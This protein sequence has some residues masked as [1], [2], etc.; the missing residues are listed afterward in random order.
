V[1]TPASVAAEIEQLARQGATP[2][3]LLGMLPAPDPQ[4]VI[5]IL[6]I[7]TVVHAGWSSYEDKLRAVQL[8]LQAE[9]D[10]RH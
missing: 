4:A 5:G 7:I 10:S 3:E 8:V 1:S 2:G 9:L 6:D